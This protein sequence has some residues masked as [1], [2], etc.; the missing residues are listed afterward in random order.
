M[1]NM[2]GEGLPGAAEHLAA[3]LLPLVRRLA[4]CAVQVEE[5]LA[6]LRDIQLINWQSP[7]GRAYRDTVSRQ[8]A[9]LR[10]AADALEGAKAAVARHAEDRVAA[11]AAECR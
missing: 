5:V 8:G 7:A 2:E 6:G 4:S 3:D 10:L 1:W 11:A 9:A